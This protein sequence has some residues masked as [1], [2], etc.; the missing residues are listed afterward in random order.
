MAPTRCA[1]HGRAYP[2]GAC[3]DLLVRLLEARVPGA[4]RL[5][6]CDLDGLAGVL[7]KGLP[8]LS[9]CVKCGKGSTA[10]KEVERCTCKGGKT[11]P[12]NLA[13]QRTDEG[14]Q[15]RDEDVTV[16]G[17][18]LSGADPSWQRGCPYGASKESLL[19]LNM[20][21]AKTTAN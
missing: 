20:I 14:A 2:C 1:A 4:N 8:D 21:K 16:D 9:A 15:W 3:T 6:D 11:T 18:R 5:W 13:E 7:Q 17:E 10:F 12:L 19:V